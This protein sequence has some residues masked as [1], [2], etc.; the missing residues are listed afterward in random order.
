[1]G[2]SRPREPLLCKQG[3]FPSSTEQGA[4]AA[5][6][7]IHRGQAKRGHLTGLLFE[8]AVPLRSL[9]LRF[10]ALSLEMD[11]AGPGR[12]PSFLHLLAISARRIIP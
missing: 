4:T 8:R 12:F 5:R 2:L 11:A 1:M 6:L 9:R 7:T 3:L 10:T